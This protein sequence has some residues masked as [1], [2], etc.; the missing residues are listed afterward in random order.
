MSS[1][2]LKDFDALLSEVGLFR[3]VIT[4]ENSLFRAVSEAVYF[5]Q[6]LHEK[7][8]TK[9]LEH[10]KINVAE[11][12]NFTGEC[13]Q[14]RITYLQQNKAN[15][16]HLEMLAMS[17][18]YRMEFVFLSAPSLNTFSVSKNKFEKKIILCEIGDHYD[19][20]YTKDHMQSSA[21]CQSIVYDILYRGVFGLKT[22][23]EEAVL[24]LELQKLPKES[25]IS[26]CSL[27]DVITLFGRDKVD[28]LQ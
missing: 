17:D 18:I 25:N 7:V 4:N 5:T 13:L 21:V 26:N 20:V 23:L 8:K 11:Y 2:L 10:L 6:S 1:K 22:E 3:K 27:S 9:C 15:A 19:L 28:T 24:F 16:G 14:E 12:Q